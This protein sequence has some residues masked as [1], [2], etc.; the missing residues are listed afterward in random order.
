[1]AFMGFV[2]KCLSTPHG[3]LG[4][5]SGNLRQPST[6][7]LSTPHG[8][9]GTSSQ[10]LTRQICNP[11]FQLHTV[12]QEPFCPKGKPFQGH[13]FFQ[14]HTVDQE[15]ENGMYSKLTCSV[16][17]TPHGRLGTSRSPLTLPCPP[18]FQLH[19]VDQELL[20]SLL[21]T[22]KLILSTPHGRLGTL[23]GQGL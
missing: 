15:P 2:L 19:T 23:K 10:T 7:N 17:S 20:P 11:I 5:L 18:S 12:D 13:H 8:R 6:T 14:L 16:L 22:C 1:M 3:R 9:L 21:R 4:T